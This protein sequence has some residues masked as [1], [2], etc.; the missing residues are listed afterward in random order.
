MLLISKRLFKS[1][2]EGILLGSHVR[3]VNSPIHPPFSNHN[4]YITITGYLPVLACDLANSWADMVLLY[5][6]AS[7]RFREAPHYLKSPL[8]VTSTTNKIMSIKKNIICSISKTLKTDVQTYSIYEIATPLK[9]SGKGVL[10]WHISSKW[11]LLEC[12]ILSCISQ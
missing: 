10:E 9:I 3:K 1:L 5:R 4:P 8:K 2:K 7:H 11:I 6:E 12:Q